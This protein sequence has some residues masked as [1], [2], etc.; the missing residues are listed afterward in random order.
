MCRKEIIE[1]LF[2]KIYSMPIQDILRNYVSLKR[3]GNYYECLC[4]FHNDKHL[5]SFKITPTLNIYKCFS[6]GE[7]GGAVKFVRNL[8]GLNYTK[9]A[10]KIAQDCNL[11]NADD[12]QELTSISESGE[13]ELKD[14]NKAVA[15][16]YEKK[17]EEIE[18]SIEQRDKVY[19]TFLDCLELDDE[20][21]KKL[22]DKRK[23]S[24]HQIKAGKYKT[25]T[26]DIN[27]ID[28]M[29]KKGLRPEDFIGVAGF[30][31][32]KEDSGQLSLSHMTSDGVIF[33]LYNAK[34]QIHSLQIRK[35][36]K[37]AISRYVFFSSSF[38]KNRDNLFGGTSA[39]ALSDV[40]FPDR[41]IHQDVLITE[42]RFK[43]QILANFMNCIVIS[44]QGVA[45]YKEK[46]LLDNITNIEKR[47]TSRSNKAFK[48]NRLI[49]AYDA[50]M[51]HNKEVLRHAKNLGQLMSQYKEVRYITWDEDKGKGIDDLII[52]EG[53]K[54]KR[55]MVGDVNCESLEEFLER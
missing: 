24:S 20:D 48:V 28:K 37:D 18:A 51:V 26:K 9:A 43:A 11:L 21:A 29:L 25:I 14:I 16:K 2:D 12:L 33:P 7:G 3:R 6:C 31:K 38:A 27:V 5:G 46:D 41:L 53:Y 55:D 34:G 47:V 8:Y 50:D 10:I 13:K 32:K 17:Y 23:L 40:T 42:G 30:Y 45:S 1:R 36:D 4:P 35:R 49:I 54:R 52:N 39:R 44:L 15:K 19:N 22:A